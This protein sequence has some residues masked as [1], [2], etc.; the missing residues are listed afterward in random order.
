MNYKIYAPRSPKEHFKEGGAQPSNHNFSFNRKDKEGETYQ[1]SRSA[2][3]EFLRYTKT[4]INH[5]F[6]MF[7]K[8]V[9]QTF[10]KFIYQTIPGM[11]KHKNY[12]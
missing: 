2:V 10:I 9:I 4:D 11:F 5:V 3:I 8:Y 7:Y 1:F 6:F 12:E